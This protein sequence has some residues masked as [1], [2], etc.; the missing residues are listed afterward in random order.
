MRDLNRLTQGDPQGKICRLLDLTGEDR[1]VA[2]PWYTGNFDDTYADVS[3]G[4]KALL[5]KITEG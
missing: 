1:D 2:D 3:R 4:C 5:K